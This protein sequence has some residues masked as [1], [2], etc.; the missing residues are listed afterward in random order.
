MNILVMGAGAVGSIFGGF[1]AKAGH[2]V[3]LVGR[4]GHMAAIRERGLHIQGIWG[5]HLIRNLNTFT[6]TREVPSG[7]LDLVLITTKS[8][9]T[10]EATRQALPLI[11]A[12]TLLVSL[13]NGLGNI[14]TISGIAGPHHV[15]GGRL[16]FG[17]EPVAE[18]RVKVTVYA[19]KV[20][21]GSPTGEVDFARIEGIAQAFTE[22]GIPTAATLEIERFIWGKMLYNCCLNALS[23]LLEVTYGELSKH[24]ATREIMTAIIVEVFAVAGRKGVTLAWCSPLEYERLLFGQL[25]PDTYSHHASMLYDVRRGKETEIDSLNGAIAKLGRESGV[26]TPANQMLTQLVKAKEEINRAKP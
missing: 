14:E 24:A 4:K 11:A 16:I 2:H 5:E 6:T 12:D 19:D 8:Y 13:Q 10:E 26:P 17:V 3:S 25:I 23:A 1:L 20:M 21:L 15:V 9:D 18:G 22:A 7:H